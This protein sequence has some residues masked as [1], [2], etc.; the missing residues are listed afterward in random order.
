[1]LDLLGLKWVFLLIMLF[2]Y[3]GY[4]SNEITAIKAL[5]FRL[6]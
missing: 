2:H 6:G 1:M 5:N 4:M 3:L